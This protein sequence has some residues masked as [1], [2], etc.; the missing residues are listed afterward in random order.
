M[1]DRLIKLFKFLKLM[2]RLRKLL[3][4][5]AVI[6]SFGKKLLKFVR[7]LQKK[8]KDFERKKD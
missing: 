2:W 4:A 5:I 8:L 1:K 3:L 7:V 6:V